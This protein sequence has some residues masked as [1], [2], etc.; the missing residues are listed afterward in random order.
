MAI[1]K[2]ITAAATSSEIVTIAFPVFPSSGSLK[3]DSP[4]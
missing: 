3:E 2:K 4:M 1:A